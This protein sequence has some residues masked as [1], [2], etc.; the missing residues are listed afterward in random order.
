M[1][2]VV[3]SKLKVEK[4]SLI[5]IKNMNTRELIVAFHKL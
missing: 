2:K 4:L 3:V 1:Y 5:F